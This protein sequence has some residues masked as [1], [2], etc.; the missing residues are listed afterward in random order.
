MFRRFLLLIIFSALAVLASGLDSRSKLSAQSRGC[1]PTV[2]VTLT[3]QPQDPEGRPPAVQLMQELAKG[4]PATI[5]I[6]S[7]VTVEMDSI[8]GRWIGSCVTLKGTRGGLDPGALMIT[9]L[10][11]HDG[12]VFFIAGGNVRVEGLRFRG[13][14]TTD[15]RSPHPSASIK[16]LV[17]VD[18]ATATIDNNLFEYWN[19]A[20]GVLRPLTGLSCR[21]TAAPV[22]ITRNYFN[23]NANED[24]G[25][26]VGMGAGC[27]RIEGNLFNKNRHAVASSGPAGDR[28]SYLARYN[29]VLEGGFTVCD[30]GL[31]HWN[32]HFDVHGTGSGGY[33][34]EAGEYFDIASNT[35]RGEQMYYQIQTRPAFMLRG[36]P[37][38]GAY[39]H[40]NVVV[41]DNEGEA[42]R[43]KPIAECLV[44]NGGVP[45]YSPEKC[46]LYVGDK[47]L[48]HGLDQPARRWRLRRRHARRCLPGERHGVVVLEC[49][50]DGMAFPPSLDPARRRSSVRKLRR[51]CTHR[52]ALRGRPQLVRLVRRN[53]VGHVVARRRYASVRLRIRRLRRR[54]RDRR[55]P[56]RWLGLVGRRAWQR[57]LDVSSR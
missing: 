42:V 19:V 44:Y 9:R 24:A 11:G 46:H 43:F 13:P 27:A 50:S 21:D 45:T 51:R 47:R 37:T 25:Y 39:F 49:R 10:R 33:G 31:C 8:H 35:I 56:R 12:P 7:N 4:S 48:Q 55:P 29:Y 3:P 52:R 15:D 38:I 2:P 57:T 32:Q 34:G 6:P 53:R 18:A 36:T 23:R 14:M 26:G 40:D 16:A 28:Q 20:V 22:T 5:L 1:P 17:V 54:Y 30:N 41:H